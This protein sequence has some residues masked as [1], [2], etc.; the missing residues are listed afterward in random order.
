LGKLKPF[1]SFLRQ[2]IAQLFFEKLKILKFCRNWNLT[3]TGRGW[4]QR[5]ERSLASST[6]DF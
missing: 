5:F 3:W 1:K 6:I 2:A 4:L